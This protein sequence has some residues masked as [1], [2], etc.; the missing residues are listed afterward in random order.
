MLREITSKAEFEES[1][2]QGLVLAD[3]YSTTC[4][5][6]KMLGFVLKDVD[7]E[8]GEGV[9]ILKV[10]YDKNKDLVADYNVAGYP[11]MILFKDGVEIDRKR[12]LQQKPVVVKMIQENK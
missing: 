11:T 9:T 4:G 8:I 1:Y 12:G 2:G 5:P 3:F 10:D 6:C 7:K